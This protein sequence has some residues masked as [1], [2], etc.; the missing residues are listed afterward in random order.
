MWRNEWEISEICEDILRNGDKRLSA[1]ALILA[2][3]VNAVNSNSD[4]WPYWK[5]SSRAADKLSDLLA[6]VTGRS[7]GTE[8]VNGRPEYVY[9]RPA[10][11]YVPTD[12][13]LRA[14]LT[15]MKRCATKHNLPSPLAPLESLAGR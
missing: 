5:A 10:F 12:A 11:S 13:E 14:T 6:R 15:P 1:Y 8:T 7:Y 2:G 4:G 3:W 9:S